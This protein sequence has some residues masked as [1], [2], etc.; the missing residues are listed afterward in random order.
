MSGDAAAHLRQVEPQ[1]R[2]IGGEGDE[3]FGRATQRVEPLHRGQA[4][5]LSLQALALSPHGTEPVERHPR[6]SPAVRPRRVAAEHEDRTLGQLGQSFGRGLHGFTM[7]HFVRPP[8]GPAVQ[9]L[10]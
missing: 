8:G 1:L 10:L 9:R 2:V 5:A 3:P 4:V 7:P 6:R